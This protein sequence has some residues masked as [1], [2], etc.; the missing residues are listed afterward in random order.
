[1]PT[2][3]QEKTALRVKESIEKHEALDGKDILALVG[4]SKGMQKN[5]GKVFNSKG[6]QEALK[7]LGF[8]VEAADLTIAKILRIGKEENQIKAS[9]E[10]Y[11][12]LGAYEQPDSG[13]GTFNL[14]FFIA[15]VRERKKAEKQS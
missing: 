3:N 1:M 12:R 13:G 11:K 15:Q 2:L 4:Y 14:S 8:S 10:I 9:Q 7:R 5:A 6:F